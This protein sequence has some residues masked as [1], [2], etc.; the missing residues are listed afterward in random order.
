MKFDPETKEL[1]TDS[2]E[3]IKVLHCPRKMRWEQLAISEVSPHRT[4]EA[5]DHPVFDTAAMSDEDV[6][7]T[8]RADP[9]TCLCIRA[10]QENVTLI[11]RWQNEADFL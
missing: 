3:F 5:C 1:F 4:C 9:S 11:P 2:G 7:A 10:S 8:V 6:L